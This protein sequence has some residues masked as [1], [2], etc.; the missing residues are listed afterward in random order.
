M[1]TIPLKRGEYITCV[2]GHHIAQVQRD[3]EAGN[4][5]FWVSDLDW[6]AIKKPKAGDSMRCPDCGDFWMFMVVMG[7]EKRARLCID[8]VWRPPLDGLDRWHMNHPG[9][10]GIFT[11]EEFEELM[12]QH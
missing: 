7:E 1:S 12:N 3:T 8:G 2:N 9:E 5:D 10:T 11:V 4:G 6:H